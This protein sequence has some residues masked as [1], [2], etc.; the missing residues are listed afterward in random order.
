MQLGHELALAFR[1]PALAQVPKQ[2]DTAAEYAL[3]RLI[4]QQGPCDRVLVA[5]SNDSLLGC[6]AVTSSIHI[7][8]LQQNFDL[9]MYDQ[10]LQPEV[11]EA[12]L[13][14]YTYAPG[15]GTVPQPYS[16]RCL[17]FVFDMYL[18]LQSVLLQMQSI[19]G[20]VSLLRFLVWAELCCRQVCM[21]S[22]TSGTQQ[23]ES[24]CCT[25]SR[26]T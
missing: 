2:A 19:Q 23:F 13:A 20:K 15:E 12:R 24:S 1:C 4:K 16:A 22:E 18:L 5:Q 21:A 25:V 14:A 7:Q 3:A 8:P 9:H 10:L 17:V 6:I 11:Y 26:R